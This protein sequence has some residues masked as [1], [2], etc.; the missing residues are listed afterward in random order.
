MTGIRQVFD[1][2]VRLET[3]LWRSVDERLQTE[4]G[5]T[6]A[7]VNVMLVI[8]STP[9]CRVFDIAQALAITVG[10]TSQAVDR[11]ES[12]GRC[13]RRAN[14]S[15]RRSSIIE[16]TPGGKA[17]LDEALPVFDAE[18]EAI[19]RKPLSTTAFTQLGATLSTLRQQATTAA[20]DSPLT[21]LS[22]GGTK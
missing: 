10:G 9:Q 21:P 20:K 16:L 11:L 14:P 4:R 15:D 2:L 22:H 18:L 12:A 1:D 13:V 5:V 6:L 19:L 7:V 17:L 3:V 8:D